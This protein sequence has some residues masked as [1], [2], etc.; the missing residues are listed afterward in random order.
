[1]LGRPGSEQARQDML[2]A[3]CSLLKNKGFQSVGTH[4]IAQAAGVI[5]ATLYR[6]WD[7]KEEIVFDVCFEHM[8]PL[9]PFLAVVRP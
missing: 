4:E 3:A 6:W 9:S 5:S 7:S 2:E 8:R 1:M